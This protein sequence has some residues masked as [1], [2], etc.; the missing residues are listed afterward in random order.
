MQKATLLSKANKA[1]RLART[2]RSAEEVLASIVAELI[3]TCVEMGNHLRAW[4][5][6]EWRNLFSGKLVKVDESGRDLQEAYSKTLGLFES[7]ASRIEDCQRRDCK[8]EGTEGF[9]QLHET[10]KRLATDF[11]TRWPRFDLAELQQAIERGDQ[12]KFQTVEEF[13]NAL[14]RDD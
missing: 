4:Q 3:D 6:D 14:L 2:A 12:E 5:R 10:I 8:V 11:E 1:A 9:R 7:T 13:R